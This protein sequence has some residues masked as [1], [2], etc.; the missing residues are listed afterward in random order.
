MQKNKKIIIVLISLFL[1]LLLTSSG[2]TAFN[3]G[4]GSSSSTIYGSSTTSYGFTLFN[5][6]SEA[7]MGYRFSVVDENGITISKTIDVYRS[8]DIY[9]GIPKAKYKDNPV[10]VHVSTPSTMQNKPALI[11][12][13]ITNG[14][15]SFLLQ[16]N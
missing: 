12:L 3:I 7:I 5:L 8:K 1:I 9:D 13:R 2:A 6:N 11:S 15:R 4:A 14:R 16:K 10:T